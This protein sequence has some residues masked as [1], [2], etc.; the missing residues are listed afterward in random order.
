MKAWRLVFG[1]VWL[2]LLGSACS[3]ADA[4]TIPAGEKSE[5]VTIIEGRTFVV[6]T[7]FSGVVVRIDAQAGQTV[8]YGQPLIWLDDSELRHSLLQAQAEI[9]SAQAQLLSLREQPIPEDIASAEATLAGAKADLAAAEAA[10]DILEASYSSGEPPEADVNSTNY[11]IEIATAEVMLAQAS[12]DK[13]NAG[14][15]EFEIQIAEHKL[16]EALANRA[17]IEAQIA[18]FVISAPVDGVISQITIQKGEVAPPGAA[19]IE[20]IDS[21]YLTLKMDAPENDIYY[22]RLGDEVQVRVNTGQIVLVNGKII[23]LF[24]KVAASSANQDN[25]Q[26]YE[27]VVKLDYHSILKPGM[28]A[29]VELPGK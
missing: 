21:S 22:F 1:L 28:P 10:A 9:D 26:L 23:R 27:L 18:K 12:L 7:E 19:L 2:V 5:P 25:E 24:P 20:I 29:V 17:A 13:L 6:A 8:T 16:S 14:A 11:A 15:S 3:N 4:T